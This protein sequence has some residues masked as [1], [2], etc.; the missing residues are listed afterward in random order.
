MSRLHA[1]TKL[2][3]SKLYKIEN[4][5]LLTVFFHKQAYGML[6]GKRQWTCHLVCYWKQQIYLTV[7]VNL[8]KS[9]GDVL[10][11]CKNKCSGIKK[12]LPWLT[13][14]W[15]LRIISDKSWSEGHVML[16]VISGG[17]NIRYPGVIISQQ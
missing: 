10:E 4:F 15:Y 13:N 2:H 7:R 12:I 8:N 9:R 16:V 5:F 14:N 6:L 1:W 17:I 11:C 3:N